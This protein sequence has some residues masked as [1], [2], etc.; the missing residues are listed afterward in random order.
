MNKY[1]STSRNTC[2]NTLAGS[3]MLIMCCNVSRLQFID[4]HID[5]ESL[6]VFECHAYPW[7][8]NIID[9][10]LIAFTIARMRFQRRW[11]HIGTALY[12]F[13]HKDSCKN[14]GTQLPLYTR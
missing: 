6:A 3:A 4:H 11:V 12:H 7:L 8:V 10:I 5:R 14:H 9:R 13:P 1:V 2:P